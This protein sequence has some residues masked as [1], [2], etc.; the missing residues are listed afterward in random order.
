LPPTGLTLLLLRRRALC[1]GLG[2]NLTP[3]ALELV[4]NVLRNGGLVAVCRLRHAS[5]QSWFVDVSSL[6]CAKP[7]V[8][9]GLKHFK[10]LN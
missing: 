6:A 4:C 2:A 3:L 5:L 10:R 7:A 9:Q 1:V 8:N